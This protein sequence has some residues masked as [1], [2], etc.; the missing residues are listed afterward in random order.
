[1][2]RK[3][4][5]FASL[6]LGCLLVL[7]SVASAQQENQS[8]APRCNNFRAIARALHLTPT[9]GQAAQAIYSDLRTTVEPLHDSIAPLR[10]ALEEL[11]DVASPVATDVGQAV[12]DI[13]AIHDQIEA[14][15]G[16][17]DDEF[18]ALLTAEQ[19]TRWET[20]QENCRQGYQ[21]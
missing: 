9:Q 5:V 4:L 7:P 15:R 2:S 18:E 21:R 12:I 3:S 11:L 16:A 1:M 8:K 17:A 6:A 10:E 20:F 13:D 14:A 19:L